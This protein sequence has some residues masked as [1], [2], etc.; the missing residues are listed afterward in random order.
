M[1]TRAVRAR[2]VLCSAAILVAV[3]CGSDAPKSTCGLRCGPAGECPADYAC[4]LDGRCYLV[5]APT[6]QSC[7]VD[8]G[9]D[10]PDVPPTIVNRVPYPDQNGVDPSV[11][12]S[13]VFSEA[14]T[15]VYEGTFRLGT[16]ELHVPVPAF[17]QY[18]DVAHSA[19]LIPSRALRPSTIYQ[20]VVGEGIHDW[21]VMPLAP[22]AWTFTTADDLT[23]PALTSVFPPDRTIGVDPLS[24]IF[25]SFTEEV[26]GLTA[27]SFYIEEDG[28]TRVPGKF[29]VISDVTIMF[30][31]TAGF[32]PLTHHTIHL[33]S[34]ITDFVGH[35]LIGAP[36]SFGFTTGTDTAPPS[37]IARTPDVGDTGIPRSIAISV[38]FSEPMIGASTTSLVLEQNGTPVDG[39]VTYFPATRVARLVPSAPLAA[40]TTYIV[41]VR[42]GLTDV[43]GNPAS[44]GDIA[45]PFTTA[46]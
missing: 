35:P 23:A 9:I 44:P 45:W 43:A 14:V 2:P 41:R 1:H 19:T 33:T 18:D 12:I 16:G 22:V 30:T 20:V 39:T 40:G 38:R 24:S 25:V 27:N 7:L 32:T 15:G 28:G 31:P 46:P 11:T 8:S 13:V 42:P 26:A 37:I 21:S 34:A 4:R 6:D 36:L 10:A 29:D 5:G 17:V 3:G